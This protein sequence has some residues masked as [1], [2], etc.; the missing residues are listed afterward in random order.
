[1]NQLKP[2]NFLSVTGLVSVCFALVIG[3]SLFLALAFDFDGDIG[4]F[5]VDS[6]LFSLFSVSAVL[7][8]LF[9]AV[10]AVVG[11]KKDIGFPVPLFGGI[12]GMIPPVGAALS[13]A[14][15]FAVNL[16]DL[17]A[18][19]DYSWFYVGET[20]LLP[21]IAAFFVLSVFPS[22]RGGKLHGAMGILACLSVNCMLF[23]SYFDFTLPLNSPIR[24]GLAVMEA[25]LLLSIL[26]TTG[27]MLGKTSPHVCCFVRSSAVSLAGG[28]SLGIFLT[29]VFVPK[30]VPNGVSVLL[31]TM[32]FFAAVSLLSQTFGRNG[33]KDEA[34]GEN[35]AELESK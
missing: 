4:H 29:A 11:K 26:V 8:V 6:P 3:V 24:N 30:N 28:I 32:S 33:L 18:N 20:V 17:L 22:Y 19:G 21:G 27:S 5:A 12:A 10:S 15:L 9:S 1:M 2:K 13:A 31:C 7:A 35:E 16:R 34:D 25:A 14:V 23:K